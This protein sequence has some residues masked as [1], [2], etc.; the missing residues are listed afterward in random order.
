MRYLAAI[1]VAISA[2][3]LHP[4]DGR[5]QTTTICGQKVDYAMTPPAPDIPAG[6]R[7]FSGIW[8]GR[9]TQPS[10]NGTDVTLCIG[11]VIARIE[12]QG[13]V[14][15][16]YVWGDSVTYHG[17][18]VAIKPGVSKW[19]GNLAGEVLHFVS[20]DGNYRFDLRVT[21]ANELRGVYSTPDGPGDVQLKRQ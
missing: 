19:R 10:G 12:P 8:V 18:G 4:G 9:A 14:R 16:R 7:A 11:F 20:Q 3:V 13:V 5:A 21:G 1:G 2:L 6:A 17:N 15:A